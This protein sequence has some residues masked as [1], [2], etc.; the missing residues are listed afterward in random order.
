MQPTGAQIKV[1]QAAWRESRDRMKCIGSAT[2]N[3]PMLT[4]HAL[5]A[6]RAAFMRKMGTALQNPGSERDDLRS[7]L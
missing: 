3:P 7:F 6:A 4:R 2:Q 1:M 5:R